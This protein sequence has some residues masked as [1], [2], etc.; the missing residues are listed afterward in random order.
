M[1]VA[2][3]GCFLIFFALVTGC[4]TMYPVT[5]EINGKP[6]FVGTINKNTFDGTSG[7]MVRSLD[8]KTTCFGKVIKT[9]S[10]MVSFTCEEEGSLTMHCSDSSVILASW[11]TTQCGRGYGNGYMDN[12]NIVT[13]NYGHGPYYCVPGHPAKNCVVNTNKAK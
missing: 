3:I 5:G 8:G 11:Y 9:Y 1:K 10:P 4:T 6:R 7:V 12:G 13:F 2:K